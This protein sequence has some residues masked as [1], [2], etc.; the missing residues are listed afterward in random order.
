MLVLAAVISAEVYVGW[1]VGG[2]LMLGLALLIVL[3][4][5][6]SVT[7]KGAKQAGLSDAFFTFAVV[8]GWPITL[9][10]HLLSQHYELAPRWLEPAFHRWR[11]Q[12]YFVSGG[13]HTLS[14]LEE[15]TKNSRPFSGLELPQ[16]GRAVRWDFRGGRKTR[17]AKAGAEG[18]ATLRVVTWNIEFGYL[19]A[20]IIEQI[21][22]LQ[23]D[24]ICLQ[25]VD[26]HSD[27]AQGVSVN[28][29][30]E[31]AQAL[32]LA[33]VWA[34]HHRYQSG[35]DGKGGGTWGCAILS[36]LD[37]V[38]EPTFLNLP[39]LDGYPRSAIMAPVDCG[40]QFGVVRVVSMHTEVC[41]RPEV[42]L[43]QLAAVAQHPFVAE[44][45]SCP[46]NSG[47]DQSRAS[48]EGP[49]TII[50]GDMNTIGG[51]F[52]MRLS[53]IHSLTVP[54]WLPRWRD[55]WFTALFGQPLTEAEWWQD[56]AL[57]VAAPGFTDADHPRLTRTLGFSWPLDC[58]VKLDWMLLRGLRVTSGCRKRSLDH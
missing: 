25:E 22:E 54:P 34:G 41:C 49:P 56:S 58:H 37:I 55:G 50:A 14:R 38:S 18:R 39:F 9:V 26:V 32:G 3:A 4:L 2:W 46:S 24:I 42:R 15:A 12:R 27:A 48:V 30:R 5:S 13:P 20:P 10:L 16:P 36:R 31:I 33:G 19:L 1:L 51:S 45:T 8:L 43:A 35:Q 52:L 21:K 53:P 17:A 44:E 7:A 40:G 57:A 11:V 6:G 28:V 47:T 23:P 29:G